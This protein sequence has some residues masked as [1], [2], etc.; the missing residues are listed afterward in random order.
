M[1]PDKLSIA[2]IGGGIGGLH[3]ALQLLQAGFD[4]HV[5]EQAPVLREVGAGFVLTPNATRLLY[6]LGLTD[7]L[8]A[9][10][11]APDRLAA[12]ALGRRHAR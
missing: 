2:V 7:K 3:A 10:G 11:V 5:Y 12:A 1:G 9:L 6:R 8:Q 4:V